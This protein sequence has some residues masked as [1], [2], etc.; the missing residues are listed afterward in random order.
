LSYDDN[1]TKATATWNGHTYPV[2]TPTNLS[3]T[4][5]FHFSNAGALRLAK[6]AWWMLARIAGWDGS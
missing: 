3:P 1:G 4:E 5:G 6:A 2:I